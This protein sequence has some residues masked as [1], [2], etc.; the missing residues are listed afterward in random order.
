[1]ENRSTDIFLE[2]QRPAPRVSSG[3]SILDEF[4]LP[5]AASS[6][7]AC[8]RKY[9]D[10]DREAVRRICCDTGFLGGPIDA[11]Y[12][13]RELFA[14]LITGPYLDNEP[15]WALV[16]EIDGRVV[17]YL[18]GSVSKYFH[19]KLIRSGFH[20]ARKMLA[21][22]V[23]G[24]Y[25]DHP[26]SEQFVRWVWITGFRERPKH[27]DR[28]A[29]MHFNLEDVYRG[30]TIGKRIWLAYERMLYAEGIDHYYGEFFSHADR[31]PEQIYARYGFEVFDRRETTMFQPE[32]PHPVHVVCAHK[33]LSA[34]PPSGRRIRRGSPQDVA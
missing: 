27:P 24:R 3:P 1:M 30:R 32:I 14:D 29:H 12:Q 15:D 34:S 23:T 26:R 7:K 8:I 21:K 19:L 10:S 2:P 25:A 13:D 18:L 16:A 22:M 4:H 9:R 33:R 17:G 31:Q 6:Q 28:A 5:A 20:T 11:I